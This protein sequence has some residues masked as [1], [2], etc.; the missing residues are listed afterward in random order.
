MDRSPVAEQDPWTGR[1]FQD[2]CMIELYK[3][4]FQRNFWISNSLNVGVRRLFLNPKREIFLQ[5]QLQEPTGNSS[6]VPECSFIALNETLRAATLGFLGLFC[7][8]SRFEI[9]TVLNSST[10]NECWMLLDA[11]H[12]DCNRSVSEIVC[13][14]KSK[15]WNFSYMHSS[16]ASG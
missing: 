7:G 5:N 1:S 8:F 16:N 15:F 11:G 13:F 6:S 3:L 2:E 10:A 9:A 4:I 14:W 12:N